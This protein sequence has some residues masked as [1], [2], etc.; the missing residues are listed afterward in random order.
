ML[1]PA[2]KSEKADSI[3][4]LENHHGLELESRRE[5]LQVGPCYQL[6][7]EVPGLFS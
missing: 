4:R 6:G 2:I 5:R 1:R 3:V 7:E